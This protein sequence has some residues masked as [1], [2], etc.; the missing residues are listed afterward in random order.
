MGTECTTEI[1]TFNDF[2]QATLAKEILES[3]GISC[4]ITGLNMSVIEVNP[5]AKIK[6]LVNNE[7]VGQAE[8]LIGSFFA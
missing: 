3:N 7:D 4:I 8:E 2:F 6:L 5:D 1:G